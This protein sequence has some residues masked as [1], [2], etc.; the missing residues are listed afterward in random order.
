MGKT[1]KCSGE[2]HYPSQLGRVKHSL[3]RPHL[4]GSYA[5]SIIAPSSLMFSTTESE[6]QPSPMIR[7]VKGQLNYE[8]G[9]N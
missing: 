7:H 8:S 5:A 9:Y 1:Q 2:G 6:N 3:T 4:L